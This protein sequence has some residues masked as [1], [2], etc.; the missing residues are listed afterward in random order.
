MHSATIRLQQL[1]D[2]DTVARQ[3]VWR[4]DVDGS[5]SASIAVLMVYPIEKPNL[6][7]GESIVSGKKS[8]VSRLCPT[9]QGVAE[10]FLEVLGPKAILSSI[11]VAGIALILSMYWA[12]D[13]FH[14]DP[15]LVAEQAKIERLSTEVEEVRHPIDERVV[16][17]GPRVDR[18]DLDAWSR[19]LRTLDQKVKNERAHLDELKKQMMGIDREVLI[20][21]RKELDQL[22]LKIQLA[23][24]GIEILR[25]RLK[26]DQKQVVSDT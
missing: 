16:G 19:L 8:I 15:I 10:A 7:Y 2:C 21:L 26:K 22:P 9:A 18:S 6:R 20:E 3:Q 13:R 17:S 11:V 5:L 25:S 23:E 24:K 12:S 4:D 1:Q 14:L